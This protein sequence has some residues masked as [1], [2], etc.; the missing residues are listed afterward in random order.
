MNAT[1]AASARP[2][3]FL[4]TNILIYATS[5]SPDH[6]AKA[7]AARAWVRR[8]DW[9]VSTQV[10]MEF[11]ANARKPKHGLLPTAAE[12]FVQRIAARRPVQALDR[13]LVLEA[14]SMRH[15][16][17]LSHWDA[18]ILCAAR[19]LGA[20]T[21]VSEDMESGRDYEGVSVLN[22]FATGASAAGV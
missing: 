11:F 6:A 1:S 18:A 2:A 5:L 14:L 22:P 3:F 13:E 9:G 10:L 4:D 15:R 7:P 8:T 12:D 20:N 16:Y 17:Y 19:R 21:V